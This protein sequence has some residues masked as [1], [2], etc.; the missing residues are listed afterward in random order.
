MPLLFGIVQGCN[1][2][3]NCVHCGG[4]VHVSQC[5]EQTWKVGLADNSMMGTI[6]KGMARM[7]QLEAFLVGHSRPGL[8]GPGLSGSIPDAVAYWRRLRILGAQRNRLSGCL[9]FLQT[10]HPDK[11]H[12]HE[13]FA[14]IC[15]W[16]PCPLVYYVSTTSNLFARWVWVFLGRGHCLPKKHVAAQN[17]G[18]SLSPTKESFILRK[19]NTKVLQ[20]VS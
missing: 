17:V 4:D 2:K 8:S 15:S 16:P 19:R 12:P 10:G 20:Y 1:I 7:T 18:F 5:I 14:L 11:K 9:L 6:P 13:H 3:F